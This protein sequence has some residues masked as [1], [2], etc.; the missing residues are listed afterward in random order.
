MA[1][2]PARLPL[3]YGFI[4][5]GSVYFKV[6]YDFTDAFLLHNKLGKDLIDFTW[7]DEDL[8][9]D[10]LDGVW[11]MYLKLKNHRD[12]YAFIATGLV[13]RFDKFLK[14][15]AYF[16]V[17]LLSFIDFL[18]DNK[19][20]L[21]V[22]AEKQTENIIAVTAAEIPDIE[23]REMIGIVLE[24]IQRRQTLIEQTLDKILAEADESGLSPIN[25]FYQYETEDEGF[26][27]H[28]SSRFEVLFGKQDENTVAQLT[29]LDGIDDMM[30]FELVQML[31]CGV[32]YKRCRSCKKLFIPSGRSDSMYC[33]RIMPGRDKPCKSIG[34]Q[35]VAKQKLAANPELF[36]YRKAYERLKKRVEMG[37][38]SEGEFDVW[39]AS[40]LEKRGLCSAKSLP[41]TEFEAW[42]NETSRRRR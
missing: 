3:A 22:F 19:V 18:L 15:N 7:F 40:A 33:D 5:E 36:L 35:L 6:K 39:N 34:A 4:S 9:R 12:D 2:N 41:Y 27:Q 29:V 42:V 30:R 1:S 25:R 32:T 26:R 16:S 37:Y 24:A 10:I 8:A 28:W 31:V 23:K 20:D 38:M 14:L 11:G 17:Y 13:Q 21:R